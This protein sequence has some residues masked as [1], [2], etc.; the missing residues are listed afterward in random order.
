MA[1]KFRHSII[2]FLI[3]LQL[4]LAKEFIDEASSEYRNNR[5]QR[6]GVHPLESSP[7]DST[8]DLSKISKDSVIENT[9]I[10]ELNLAPTI[11]GTQS[12][13]VLEQQS[14]FLTSL[15]KERIAFKI[16]TSFHVLVNGVSLELQDMAALETVSRLKEVKKVWPMLKVS[17]PK[18]LTHDEENAI[19]PTINFATNMTGVFESK[20][21][22]GVTGRGVRVGVIDSGIDYKHPALGGCLGKSCKVAF[23]YD[24]VGD[25]YN[26]GKKPQPG[27][28]PMDC[29]GHGTHVAGIIAGDNEL[30]QGVAPKATLGAYRVFGCSGPTASDIIVAAM[31]KAFEDGM[32]VINLSLGGGSSWADYPTAKAGDRLSKAGMVV[33]AAMGNDGAYGLWETSAPSVGKEVI[34][35]ASFD[36]KVFAGYTGKVSLG[37]VTSTPAEK[38]SESS[39]SGSR[40]EEEDSVFSDE[41]ETSDEENE[42]LATPSKG[43]PA[44][45]IRQHQK[46]DSRVQSSS[47]DDVDFTLAI[48]APEGQVIDDTKVHTLDSALSSGL[49][50]YKTL[51]GIPQSVRLNFAGKTVLV[52]RGECEFRVKLNVAKS[53]N[54]SAVI[55]YNN[56]PGAFNVQFDAKN[57]IPY[58]SIQKGDGERLEDLLTRTERQVLLRLDG[59]KSMHPS[60]SGGRISSFSSWGLG[61]DLDIKP[62]IGA[63]GGLIFSTYPRAKGSYATLSGTSMATPHVAGCVALYL[64]SMMGKDV[65]PSDVR[66]AL[67]NT[68]VPANV[69]FELNSVDSVARQGA[70]MVQ[71]DKAIMATTQ[72]EPT[73]VSLK[74]DPIVGPVKTG[75]FTVKNTGKSTLAYELDHVPAVSVSAANPWAP[76]WA[77][78]TVKAKIMPQRFSLSPG[79]SKRVFIF[80]DPSVTLDNANK[81]IYSGYVK[82]SQKI[83]GLD[84]SLAPLHVPYAGF[85][86]RYMDMRIFPQV[87]GLPQVIKY[88]PTTEKVS[89]DLNFNFTTHRYL[90]QYNETVSST[91][92][93]A[94]VIYSLQHPTPL[95][96]VFLR[97]ATTNRLL[98]KVDELKWNGRVGPT[99]SDALRKYMWD[100]TMLETMYNYNWRGLQVGVNKPGVGLGGGLTIGG[101]LRKWKWGFGLGNGNGAREPLPVDSDRQGN[102]DSDGEVRADGPKRVAVPRGRYFLVFKAQR[103]GAAWWS[104]VLKTHEEWKS[105]VINVVV[106]RV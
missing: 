95:I 40:N 24:F 41:E 89:Q 26:V 72:V 17:R 34:A 3:L 82:I 25:D 57:S 20:K 81:W 46:R 85:K 1:S 35:V 51:C 42:D 80:L 52:A 88:I 11:E 45:T 70:G 7:A 27:N 91:V 78:Y 48:S 96:E 58:Y 60:P 43:Q 77:D 22:L 94:A 21:N 84:K 49:N 73:K 61:P 12:Q 44:S 101:K 13:Y 15:R 79:A 64:E 87:Q 100:G 36:N 39:K 66:R 32:D 74:E 86:G 67:Q 106:P 47:A 38:P 65:L 92:E 71:V 69:P 19:K 90:N 29:G 55:F 93:E 4:V 102:E 103:A 8:L 28:D 83:T 105:P 33:V 2:L 9:W 23:G 14:Q 50:L 31:E 37:K 10:V 76:V 59:K 104:S 75:F 99:P 16:R 18:V 53:L 56:V 62:D 6:A 30:V 5:A 54:A 98:G 97:D 63:P 68:A